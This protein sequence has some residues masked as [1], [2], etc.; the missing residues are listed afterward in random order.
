MTITTTTQ[1]PPSLTQLRREYRNLLHLIR[2]AEGPQLAMLQ[3]ML[4]ST[5]GDLLYAAQYDRGQADAMADTLHRS[6]GLS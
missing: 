3:D 6:D 5:E 2:I 4:D 1:A